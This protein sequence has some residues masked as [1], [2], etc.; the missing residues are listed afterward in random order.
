MKEQGLPAV[1]HSA[2]L[3]AKEGQALI[4][5]LVAAAVT[6]SVLTAAT[7]A[8]VGQGKASARNELGRK[9]YYAAEAGAEYGIIKL[10]RNPGSCPGSDSLTIDSLTTTITYTATGSACIVRSKAVGNNTI[11][12]IQVQGS[13][14]S[15]QIFNY[16]GWSEIETP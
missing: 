6:L 13:Y 7:L 11:K 9:A 4:V 10:M 15:N 5:L 3:R 16:S 8:A 2:M 1:A 12:T 14:D